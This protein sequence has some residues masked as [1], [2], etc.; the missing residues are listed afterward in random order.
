M[1]QRDVE[2]NEVIRGEPET[3]Q[4]RRVRG[5]FFQDFDGEVHH[6]SRK[7]EC[8]GSSQAHRCWW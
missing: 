2:E 7:Q 4:L 3:F 8:L 5:S 6:I 1:C